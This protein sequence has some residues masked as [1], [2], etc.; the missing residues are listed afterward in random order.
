MIQRGK[1]MAALGF[2]SVVS[3]AE[4]WAKNSIYYKETRS[5]QLIDGIFIE[6]R[7][8]GDCQKTKDICAAILK[9]PTINIQDPYQTL[10]QHCFEKKSLLGEALQRRTGF[11]LKGST[12]LKKIK[13]LIEEILDGQQPLLKID[14][15]SSIT[16]ETIASL[17]E[18]LTQMVTC[19]VSYEIFRK[20]VMLEPCH[21]AFEEKVVT[22]LQKQ[23]CPLC[24]APIQK[25]APSLFHKQLVE[26][27]FRA[28]K[29]E[30]DKAKQFDQKEYEAELQARKQPQDAKVSASDPLSAP[31]E[32]PTEEERQ[33]QLS[34]QTQ[35]LRQ[36][37]EAKGGNTAP[38]II[39]SRNP[40]L[41]QP[42]QS[43]FTW[44]D[45]WRTA[46]FCPP[47]EWRKAK[48]G[49]RINFRA[50]A[51]QEA[52]QQD[53]SAL[54]ISSANNTTRFRLGPQDDLP[55]LNTSNSE[56]NEQVSPQN[57]VYQQNRI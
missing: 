39:P 51:A 27:Y 53:S 10:R 18:G 2:N 30:N 31:Y 36:L 41:D 29:D 17:K 43:D 6:I 24:V 46:P 50:L 19:P 52:A 56:S 35:I 45:E 40:H 37:S 15:G 32:N 12:V 14:L 16:Q 28:F 42:V 57:S 23:C 7:R 55:P 49:R 54:N 26:Q 22:Q 47:Y 48:H 33:A 3:E 11:K 5:Q 1:Y 8:K 9:L 25:H 34:I 38:Q 44:G 20:P 4:K 13:K 21:H